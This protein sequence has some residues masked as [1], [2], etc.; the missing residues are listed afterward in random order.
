MSKIFDVVKKD[1]LIDLGEMPEARLE[2]V[3]QSQRT[4]KPARSAPATASSLNSGRVHRLRVS[5]LSPVFP[6]DNGHHAAAE[7]YRIIRTKI[8]HSS[9]RSHLIVVSSPSSG[10]GKTVTSINIAGSLALK[11]DSRVLLVDGDLRQPCVSDTLGIPAAPGLAEVLSGAA[12]LESAL[13]RAEQFPNLFILSAGNPQESAPE[14]LDSQAWRVFIE[15]VRARF[16]N[17]IFDAP[18]I[19]TVADYDLLQLACDAIIVVARPDHSQRAACLNALKMVPREKLLGVVLNCVENWWLWQTPTYGY[20]SKNL[21]RRRPLKTRFQTG[22]AEVELN[23]NKKGR[24]DV[25][26]SQITDMAFGG[27]SKSFG[28]DGQLG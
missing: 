9:K 27:A 11:D 23:A 13:V 5:A 4:S 2:E 7:Q 20:Y 22:A 15:Q 18:P 19:G 6:F 8:L 28:A 26:K 25:S 12:M 14:L 3:Q 10:D 1:N 17:V 24:A 16:P 21:L